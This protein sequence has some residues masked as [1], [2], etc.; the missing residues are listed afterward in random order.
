[1][2]TDLL[3][4]RRD[5]V[6][7]KLTSAQIARLDAHGKRSATRAGEVLVE[8]GDRHRQIL[9]VLA[10]S[11]ELV[12]PGVHGETPL[13]LLEAGDFSGEM[14][15]LRGV[16]GFVRIRVRDAGAVLAINEEGLRN[17]VQTDAELS[18]ILMRAFILRRVGLLGQG[19][20]TLIGSRHSARA[21]VDP[22]T[23]RRAAQ[24]LGASRGRSLRGSRAAGHPARQRDDD[25]RDDRGDRRRPRRRCPCRRSRP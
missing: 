20:V 9:V 3:E 15:T 21:H 19:E 11:I 4:K 14:S 24:A 23:R 2:A 16:P 7:P 8:P 1:M 13:T 6:F 17:V 22:R 5:Q 18:E 25:D 12:I 10:G